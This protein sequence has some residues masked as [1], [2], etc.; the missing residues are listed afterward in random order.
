[1]DF[2]K[3][4]HSYLFC[5]IPML[6]SPLP[7]VYFSLPLFARAAE[8]LLL[9]VQKDYLKPQKELAELKKDASQ[10]LSKHNSKL[11]DAQ[12]LVNDALADINETNRLFPLISS[13]L[14]ELNVRL[15]DLC[16]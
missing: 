11:Q 10:L 3:K 12:D 5:M 7:C 6:V 9:H 4:V 14:A 8:N 2:C 15:D 1:M 13:N 16:C